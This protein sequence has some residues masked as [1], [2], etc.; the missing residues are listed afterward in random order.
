VSGDLERGERFNPDTS[1]WIERNKAGGA[2]DEGGADSFQFSGEVT[3]FRH[4]GP[5]H[6]WVDG[7]RV[8]PNFPNILRIETDSDEVHYDF[9]VSDDLARGE[10]YDTD[11]SDSINDTTGEG[12][13]DDGVDTFRYSGRIT[14][15]NHSNGFIQIFI[16]GIRIDPDTIGQ[17]TTPTPTLTPTPE[18]NSTATSEPP[19]ID[20]WPPELSAVDMIIGT[21]TSLILATVAV[22]EYRRNGSD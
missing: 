2:V 21:V 16:N 18:A 9:S 14:D 13:V 12:G 10:E 3:D 6:L 15:F 4:E 20:D 19:L 22:L 8:D 11:G 1:D 17:V 7:N 5:I